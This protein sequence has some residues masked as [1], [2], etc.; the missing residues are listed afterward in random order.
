MQVSAAIFKAYD[1]RGIVPTT[2]NEAVAEGLG[3]AFGISNWINLARSCRSFT[4]QGI[5]SR[6]LAAATS[7][8]FASSSPAIFLLM[9]CNIVSGSTNP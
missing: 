9:S 5:P 7:N 1:I 2:L 6:N 4:G 8:S 3:K